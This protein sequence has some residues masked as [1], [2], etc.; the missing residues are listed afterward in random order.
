M[1]G[2]HRTF[3]LRSTAIASARYSAETREL[4]LFF[5]NGKMYTYTDVPPEIADG[6]EHADSAGA[7]FHA[8]IKD[9]YS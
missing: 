7:Y 3:P 9:Q 1:P 5:T 4:D 2:D 6:L 8:N